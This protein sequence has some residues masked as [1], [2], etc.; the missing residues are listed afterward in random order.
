MGLFTALKSLRRTTNVFVRIFLGILREDLPI[1]RPVPY[2]ITTFSWY[3]SCYSVYFTSTFSRQQNSKWNHD[4]KT[5]DIFFKCSE[6]KI[7]RQESNKNI[8]FTNKLNPVSL[9]K[10][11]LSLSSEYLIFSSSMESIKD[12]IK[13]SFYLLLGADVKRDILYWGRN[14]DWGYMRSHLSGDYLSVIICTLHQADLLLGKSNKGL[15]DGR[16]I[17]THTIFSRKPE[18]EPRRRMEDNIKII[19]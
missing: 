5:D 3:L 9:R 13:L 15:W 6:V 2:R 17:Y 1:L 8:I 14:I 4:R 11:L 10:T 16:G 18:G 19:L 7:S 12:K